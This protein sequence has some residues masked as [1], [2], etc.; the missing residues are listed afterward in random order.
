MQWK[1]ST[2][3]SFSKQKTT[4]LEKIEKYGIGLRYAVRIKAGKK[5]RQTGKIRWAVTEWGLKKKQA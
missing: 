2:T 3:E 1:F 5:F 4:N